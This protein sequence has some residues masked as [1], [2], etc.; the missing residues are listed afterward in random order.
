M[1][2]NIAFINDVDANVAAAI[3]AGLCTVHGLHL[4]VTG[5]CD[6]CI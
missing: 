1:N 5:Q 3:D 4:P 2:Q 6:S